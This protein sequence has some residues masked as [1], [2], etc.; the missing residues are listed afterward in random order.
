MM[1]SVALLLCVASACEALVA[2][3][4]LPSPSLSLARRGGS[5]L[6]ATPTAAADVAVVILA[7]GVGSRMKAD[8]CV[9]CSR[10]GTPRRASHHRGT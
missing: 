1:R 6:R 7:G 2:R 9:V 3:A 5:A 8:R 4:R 10:H